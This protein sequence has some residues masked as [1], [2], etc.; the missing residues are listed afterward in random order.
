MLGGTALFLAGHAFFKWAMFGLLPW[1]RLV[2]IAA[3][4]ALIPV[5]FAIT[6]R[7]EGDWLQQAV[8]DKRGS[9]LLR[10][11]RHR[12]DLGAVARLARNRCTAKGPRRR[13]DQGESAFSPT[14]R[15]VII[16]IVD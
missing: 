12:E 5:G 6:V 16:P 8:Q 9:L 2:A 13:G 15:R 1:S 14:I 11:R 4:A 3:L 10:S 7:E